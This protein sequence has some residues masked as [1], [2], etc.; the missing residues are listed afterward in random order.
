M[1]SG[2]ALELAMKQAADRAAQLTLTR[3]RSVALGQLP[4]PP[5]SAP[6]R[7]T[8]GP[9]PPQQQ[10]HDGL[11]GAPLEEDELEGLIDN[12]AQVLQGPLIGSDVDDE[13]SWH[14]PANKGKGRA[15]T[16]TSL[17]P[18]EED[19]LSTE[20]NSEPG[21]SSPKRINIVFHRP[22]PPPSPHAHPHPRAGL[23]ARDE[24]GISP[25]PGGQRPKN[26]CNDPRSRDR[27]GRRECTS[28]IPLVGGV[29]SRIP[30]N[31]GE[32]ATTIGS[33]S[34]SFPRNRSLMEQNSSPL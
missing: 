17:T 15:L 20:R 25:C 24:S 12:A 14:P 22:P 7:Y 30:K 26:L 1:T 18:S 11:D 13:A 5:L 16:P 23:E 8:N 34:P 9:P 21:K 10:G 29:N 33:V 31:E 3:S 6:R 2:S 28:K 19:D 4:G 27:G 32:L